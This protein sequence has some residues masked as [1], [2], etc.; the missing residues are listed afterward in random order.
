MEKVFNIAI[1]L[2]IQ[3]IESKAGLKVKGHSNDT[4]ERN[5]LEK[6]EKHWTT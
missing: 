5:G 3:I 6:I 4:L 2:A 1:V